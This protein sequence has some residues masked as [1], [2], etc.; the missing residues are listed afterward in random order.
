MTSTNSKNWVHLDEIPF[1]LSHVVCDVSLLFS[2]VIT[3]VCR[4]W[5]CFSLTAAPPLAWARPPGLKPCFLS[6]V[7]SLR[8]PVLSQ[9]ENCETRSGCFLWKCKYIFNWLNWSR[10]ITL[11]ETT[12]RIKCIIPVPKKHVNY[13][14]LCSINENIRQMKYNECTSLS[15][16]KR[17]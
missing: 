11:A 6:L 13:Q 5:L 9:M 1:P 17:K 3:R 7:A 8:C 4:P 15:L 14:Y 10:I 12:T 16:N 2:P